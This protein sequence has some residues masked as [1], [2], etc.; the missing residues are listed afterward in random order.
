MYEIIWDYI[1]MQI[2]KRSSTLPDISWK[3]KDYFNCN[4]Y[5]T[6]FKISIRLEAKLNDLSALMSLIPEASAGAKQKL[7]ES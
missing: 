7:S 5:N 6:I 4:T 1:N 3:P 2:V